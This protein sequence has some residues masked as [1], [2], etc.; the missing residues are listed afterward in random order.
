MAWLPPSIQPALNISDIKKER[1]IMYFIAIDNTVINAEHIVCVCRHRDGKD[2]I[3]L[4]ND[5]EIQVTDISGLLNLL[6]RI[7]EVYPL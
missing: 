4:D 6:S 5:K 1:E 3:E 2:Y 7:G